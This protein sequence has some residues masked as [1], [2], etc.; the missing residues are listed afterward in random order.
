MKINTLHIEYTQ[1]HMFFYGVIYRDI[2]YHFHV[3]EYLMP[4]TYKVK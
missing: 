1:G 2:I 4:R 3:I